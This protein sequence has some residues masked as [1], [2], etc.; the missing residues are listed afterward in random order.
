MVPSYQLKLN[1]ALEHF[2]N[3]NTLAQAW[4]ESEAWAAVPEC[5]IETRK[6]IVRLRVFEPPDDPRIPLLIGDCVHNLRAALDH[7][8]YGLAIA[9][10]G[11]D[12]PPNE[13]TTGFPITT[14]SAQFDGSLGTKIG[15]KKKMPDGLYDALEQLQPY[16]GRDQHLWVIHELDNLDKHRFPPVVAAIASVPHFYI[17]TLEVNYLSAPRTGPLE[18]GEPIIEYIP[19]ADSKEDFRFR[20]EM[21]IG[22]GEG[23][24][25]VQGGFVNHI[26][27]NVRSYVLRRVFPAVEPFL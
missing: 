13:A 22:F 27:A 16:P 4:I 18:D 26:V 24:P 2:N 15:P 7:L 9:V 5:E 14:R 20:A 6:H 11:I 23:T 19:I 17:G 12:P 10:H 25:V 3:F 21:T 1:R 8:A